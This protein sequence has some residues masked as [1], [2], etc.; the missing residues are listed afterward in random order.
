LLEFKDLL[1]LAINMNISLDNFLNN[2]DFIISHTEPISVYEGENISNWSPKPK[3]FFNRHSDNKITFISFGNE[4]YKR[5]MY[6]IF[7]QAINIPLTRRAVIYD[8]DSLKNDTEFWS[9]NGNFI[10][11][12]PIGYGFYMWKSYIVMKTLE[13]LNNNEILIYCDAGCNINPE[14]IERLKEYISIVETHPT[15]ILAFKLMNHWNIESQY[16]KMDVLKELNAEHL[17]YTQQNM[18]TIIIMRKTDTSL[19]LTK[20]WYELSCNHSLISDEPSKCPNAPDFREHRRD[21]SFYSLLTKL[22]NVA[23]IPDDTEVDSNLIPLKASRQR[24][25]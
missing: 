23:I 1:L 6:R 20:K 9:K 7:C 24:E 3:Y 19:E 21:Q 5:A 22:Y 12:N 14:G 17:L 13:K 10:E 18:A 11:S 25:S 4:S 15:G 16:T 8:Q 2:C